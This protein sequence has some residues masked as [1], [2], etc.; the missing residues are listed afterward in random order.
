MSSD[1]QSPAASVPREQYERVVAALD[2]A[3]ETLDLATAAL[4]AG[5]LP[6][7]AILTAKLLDATRELRAS[8]GAAIAGGSS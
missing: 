6:E 2:Q 3:V 1:R 5:K 8:V 7:R 4:S